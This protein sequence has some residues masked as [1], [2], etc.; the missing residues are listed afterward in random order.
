MIHQP[1]RKLRNKLLSATLL[2]APA[3]FFTGPVLNGQVTWADYE[4]SQM[5][6][7]ATP[8]TFLGRVQVGRFANQVWVYSEGVGSHFYLPESHVLELGAWGYA[9]MLDPEVFDFHWAGEGWLYA[10]YGD[11]WVH[12]PEAALDASMGWVFIVNAEAAVSLPDRL[13]VTADFSALPPAE[14]IDPVGYTNARPA[15]AGDLDRFAGALRVS[16]EAMAEQ[17]DMDADLNMDSGPEGM[18]FTNPLQFGNRFV[19]FF[20]HPV[21][22]GLIDFSDLDNYTGKVGMTVRTDADLS[23]ATGGA[24]ARLKHFGFVVQYVDE[25]GAYSRLAPGTAAEDVLL[26][27]YTNEWHEP[28]YIELTI[29]PQGSLT[30]K[31]VYFHMETEI[32]GFADM[33][34]RITGGA[35][36]APENTHT[37]TNVVEM[38]AALDA[39]RAADGP[40]IIYVDG[41]L[42]VEDWE[43]ADG[44]DDR[45]FGVGDDIRNL[46][47]IGVGSNGLLD[48]VGFKV[49]G[50]NVIFENLTVRDLWMRNAFEINNARY[51]KVT[52]CTMHGDTDSSTRFDEML[53]VKNH[54]RY[55]IISWNH[56]HTDPSGRSILMGSNSGVEALP[57]RK[58][59]IHHNWFE[60][61][62]SRHP[63][64]RGGYT[65]IYNNYFNNISGGT[66]VRPRARVRIEN[67][68]Y[69]NV[70]NAIFPGSEPAVI[71]GVWEVSGNIFEGGN[72][73]HH[74]TESTI[75]LHFESAYTYTLDPAADVPDIV[76]AGAGAQQPEDE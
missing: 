47:V 72:S 31:D 73:S 51:I 17:M 33:A 49:H 7:A 68:V 63:L 4:V 10:N 70:N 27:T 42:T 34:D 6:W 75:Q 25:A 66:N 64:V 46:S 35:G 62:G 20:Y 45:Q 44:D 58:T 37:V 23:E 28:V 55:V 50:A 14:D 69:R 9:P 32:R 36:A 59:I 22:G 26:E 41:T 2:C 39:V 30:V 38:F 12:A 53:S 57:D 24:F 3:C 61:V 60:G 74:R 16:A 8:D 76:M 1:F 71:G 52:R 43:A 65:H 29:P 67:N 5:G 13:Y 11:T 56:F 48:G 54:A 40:S 21:A 19:R 15:L 18:T